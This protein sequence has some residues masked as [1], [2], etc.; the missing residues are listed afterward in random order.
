MIPGAKRLLIVDDNAELREQMRRYLSD[1]EFTIDTAAD[2]KAMDKALA[3][4]PVDL[5]ILD[6]M[7]PG[8]DGLSICRR[9][10]QAGEPAVIMV[11]A[12][13]EEI[14]RVLGLELGAD[15]YLAKPFSP[16]E[17]LARARAVLR[18]RGD[19]PKA[20]AAPEFTFEGF[21][22][23]SARRELRA[24]DGALILLTAIESSVLG[25]LLLRPQQ[26]M[27]RDELLA[28]GQSD[29]E[30]RAIDLLVSRLR[31][32]LSIHGGGALIRTQ[33]GAGYLLACAV[34]RE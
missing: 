17:L 26:V 34:S 32:K 29:P 33:R 3:D 31:R 23:N 16:R 30:S 4:G 18:R 13:G 7:L 25:A 12:A 19:G 1:Y 10:V 9:L 24:P 21:R 8:E 22:Y 27:T 28:P 14:D 5:V 11:S 6:L 20:L 2:A 15:D